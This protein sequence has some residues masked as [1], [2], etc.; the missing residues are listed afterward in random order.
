MAGLAGA[1]CSAAV[2]LWTAASADPCFPPR[3]GCRLALVTLLLPVV[4]LA[5]QG[6][7]GFQPEAVM[8]FACPALGHSAAGVRAC[9]AELVV[10]VAVAAGP[11]M[12]RLLPGNL[13]AKLRAQIEADLLSRSSGA[14]AAAG[15]GRQRGAPAAPAAGARQQQAPAAAAAAA[16]VAAVGPAPKAQQQGPAASAAAAPA[17]APAALPPP[18]E[19]ADPAAYEA[20]VR[21]R[22]VRLGPTHPDVAE[23]ICNLAILHN[24][25]CVCRG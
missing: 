15:S 20:E 6:G 17:P 9:A 19:G 23:A 7:D 22:E 2:A 3:C 21:E 5:G 18:E 4:G 1:A 13:N 12:L 11:A 16:A 14:S 10:E 25:V 8:D 24:Q